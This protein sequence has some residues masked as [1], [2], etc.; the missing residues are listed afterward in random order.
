MKKLT[1]ATAFS[2][3]L[4]AACGGGSGVDKTPPSINSLSDI[5]LEADTSSNAI[6]ISANDNKSSSDNLLI[7]ASSSNTELVSDLNLQLSGTGNNTQLVITPSADTIGTSTI[8]VE[9]T[10]EA[11]NMATTDFV[12]SVT[13]REEDST[14]LVNR[15]SQLDGDDEP[16]FIN[17]VTLSG[18]VDD[19]DGFDLI[20]DNN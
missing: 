10:D 19:T 11:G 7:G 9:A 5:T 17:Q 1:L 14:N 6:A 13:M 18:E 12:V 4:L 8:T 20:V 2:A 3:C 15:I 16:E